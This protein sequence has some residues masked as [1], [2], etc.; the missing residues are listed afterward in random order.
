MKLNNTHLFQHQH[1]TFQS[2]V[3]F[4]KRLEWISTSLERNPPLK[5]LNAAKDIN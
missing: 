4:L 2:I 1:D 5:L 3:M